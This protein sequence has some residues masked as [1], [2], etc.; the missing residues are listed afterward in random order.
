M[1]EKVPSVLRVGSGVSMVLAPL[2]WLASSALGPGHEA[3]KTLAGVLPYI[4]TDPDRFLAS[5]LLGLLSLILMVPAVLGVAHLL[6]RQMPLLALAGAAL[7]LLGLLSLA[8]LHGVQLV[9]HQM[10]QETADRQQMVALLERLEGGIGTKVIFVGLFLGLFLGW[11][12]LSTGLVKSGSVP[13]AIPV[14]LFASLVLNFAGLERTSR[15]LFL[16]GL[17]WLGA[18]VLVAQNDRGVSTESDLGPRS[19]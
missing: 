3:S 4:A 9:Q 19:T 14:F 7:V 1:G 5:V 2:L 17:A 6:H 11:V 10:I 15:L 12:I 8:V 18:L 16:I 13:K